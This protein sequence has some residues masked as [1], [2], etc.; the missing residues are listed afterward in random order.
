[1]R[2]ALNAALTVFYSVLLCTED[3]LPLYSNEM[4]RSLIS[5]TEDK[6][7]TPKQGHGGQGTLL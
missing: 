7:K 1:M 2:A 5:F 4:K 6:K 3:I